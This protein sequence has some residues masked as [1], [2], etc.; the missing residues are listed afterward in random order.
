MNERIKG[1]RKHLKLSQEEFAK[2]LG[3]TGSGLSNIESGKRS[4]T[5]QMTIA[6]CQI[7][8][9]SKDWLCD[10]KGEM[11]NKDSRDSEID[12]FINTVLSDETDDF[13]RRLILMLSKL[14]ANEWKVLE[15]KARELFAECEEDNRLVYRAA[16][17]DDN[18]EH[19]IER[20]SASDLA[21]LASAE[22]VTS[23]EDL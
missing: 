5:E 2:R 14:N 15:S 22:T 7:F 19:R 3:I 17:S 12:T 1:I 9:V 13:K 8:N 23:E 16:M 4:V 21:K 11:F 10:G 6:I 18:R 20:R